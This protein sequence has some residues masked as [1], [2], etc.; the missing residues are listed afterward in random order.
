MH[1]S[2]CENEAKPG[3]RYCR[4]CHAAYMRTWRPRH[5]DLLPLARKKAICRAYA[6]VYQKRGKLIPVGC[7]VCGA[8]AEKHHESYEKPLD[9]TWLCRLH[10]M[11]EH[12]VK[13]TNNSGVL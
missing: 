1:C 8:K 4:T 10:H 12:G 5:S 11:E 9:V 2:R 6:N 13:Y 3:Q 7:S